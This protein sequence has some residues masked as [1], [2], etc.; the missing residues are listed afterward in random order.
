MKNN[1]MK[2]NLAIPCFSSLSEETLYKSSMQNYDVKIKINLIKVAK[3]ALKDKEVLIKK[4]PAGKIEISYKNIG[5]RTSNRLFPVVLPRSIEIDKEFSE[6]IGLYLGD[7]MTS[8]NTITMVQFTNKDFDICRFMI[9]FF[10]KK[11][12]IPLDDI[13][14]DIS[15]RFGSEKNVLEKWSKV[16]CIMPEKFKIYKADENYFDETLHIRINGT[17]FRKIFQHII[18]NYLQEIKEISELRRGFLR[19]YFAAEGSISSY[20]RPGQLMSSI[21]FSYNAQKEGWLRNFCIDCLREESIDSNYKDEGS[22]GKI[23]IC[24]WSNYQKLWNIIVFERC[25]RKKDLFESLVKKLKIYLELDDKFR[26]DLFKGLG[27]T[28]DGIAKLVSSS[29]PN[30]SQIMRGVQP[31]RFEQ[32]DVLCKAAD[33]D[34]DLAKNKVTLLKVYHSKPLNCSKKFVEKLFELKSI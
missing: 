18:E 16:L 10:K 8:K 20:R 17:V 1:H 22:K 29:Q 9:E 28:Q 32:L 25:K 33:V 14:L 34:I 12:N 7:G 19:G 11:F 4:L 24:N 6:A 5:Y 13:D 30:V 23:I 26:S 31:I 15:Y 3:E 2:I 27:M 21:S